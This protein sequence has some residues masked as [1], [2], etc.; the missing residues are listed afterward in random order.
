[1]NAPLNTESLAPQ[2][3][4]ANPGSAGF[5]VKGLHHYAYKCKDPVATRRF[6]EDTLGMPLEDR[7]S[8][9]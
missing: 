2:S 1:M 5:A 3:A 6:W 9:V 8:V 4:S 7:K